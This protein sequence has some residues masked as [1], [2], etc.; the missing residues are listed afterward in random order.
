M[1]FFQILANSHFLLTQ[2]QLC[3]FTI[4]NSVQ[5]YK[6]PFPPSF[7]PTHPLSDHALLLH[8]QERR[9]K[10][11]TLDTSIL[12]INVLVVQESTVEFNV[13]YTPHFPRLTNYS[14]FCTEYLILVL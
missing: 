5:F 4:F 12:F 7:L 3:L 9:K 11:L 1:D 2:M 8:E 13:F 6:I 14:D 10:M